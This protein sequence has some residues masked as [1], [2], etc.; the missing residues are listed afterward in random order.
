M[1]DAPAGT[2]AI[3][4]EDQLRQEHDE[5][6]NLV[7]VCLKCPRKIRMCTATKYMDSCVFA[8]D[9]VGDHKTERGDLF[10]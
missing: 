10:Q 3:H 2:C 7:A 1:K 5:L 8:K 4:N 6:G 9:H